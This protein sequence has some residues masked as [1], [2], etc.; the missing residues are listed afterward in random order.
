MKGP[1]TGSGMLA[2]L[3]LGLG[4][5]VAPVSAEEPLTDA[6][7]FE[8]PDA[9]MTVPLNEL[10]SLQRLEAGEVSFCL[11]GEDAL[12]FGR[13]TARSIGERMTIRF[14]GEVVSDP[15]I[16]SAIPGGC[17]NTAGAT[18]ELIAAIPEDGW[19][20]RT[21]AWGGSWMREATV[22]LLR[23]GLDPLA[24]ART[25]AMDRI[26]RWISSRNG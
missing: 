11:N 5:F 13:L 8:F 10:R 12:E 2:I 18:K 22:S 26:G 14:Q 1:S 16:R 19:R 7:V 17:G 24:H 4:P 21:W 3:A 20:R 15:I 6:F 23:D 9:T 25:R